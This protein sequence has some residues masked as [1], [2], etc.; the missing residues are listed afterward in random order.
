M[1]A[2][3]YL[4]QYRNLE[5]QIRLNEDCLRKMRQSL[6]SIRSSF[7]VD[8]VRSVVSDDAVYARRL[9]EVDR[10]ER[11]ILLQ[12]DLK[13]RLEKQIVEAL[14]KMECLE[15]RSAVNYSVFLKYRFL[16]GFQW[17]QAGYS[18]GISRATVFRWRVAALELFPVPENP[19]DVKKELSLLSAA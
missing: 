9:E 5:E 10:L 17:E 13:E 18:F 16:M 15:D 11:T 14:K 1:K 19:I 8:S 12:K 2:V 6:Y 7:Q 3:T 4:E